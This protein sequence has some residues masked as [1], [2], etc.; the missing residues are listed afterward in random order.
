M[1]GID[2]RQDAMFS[3]VSLEARVPADHPLRPVREMVDTALK[4]MSRD[5]TRMYSK[6]GRPSIAPERLLRALLLQ[7]FYSIR[8]E[9]LLM[10]AL[11]YNLLFRWFVGLTADEPVWE[12][13]TFSKNRDRLI[14]ADIARKFFTH[15]MKQAENAGLISDEHFSVDGTLIEAWAS[16]KSFRHKEGGDDDNSDGQG[17]N[18]GRNFHGEKRTNETHASTTDPEARMY[19]KSHVGAARLCFAGHVLME[20]RNGLAVDAMVSVADGK[21]ER[22]AAL[23]MLARRPGARVTVGADKGYDT[24]DFIE[25]VR[26]LGVTP[27]IAQNTT[28]RGGS[29]IDNRT[30][31]HPGYLLSQVIRKR[32]EEIFGWG[33]TIGSMRKTKFRGVARVGFDTLLTMAGYNLVRMRRLIYDC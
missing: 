12:R 23:E 14:A 29:G 4:A 15:I 6:E 3:Y 20:N 7:V 22:E 33:K 30:T 25:S 26:A 8:S 27:H 17:R 18:A 21:S 24:R 32:I 16:H 19:R 10:E 2:N 31:R 5:F 11:D 13:S 1:R 9:R 28:R